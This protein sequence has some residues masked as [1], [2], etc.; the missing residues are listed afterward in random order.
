MSEPLTAA[1]LDGRIEALLQANNFGLSAWN[2]S[3]SSPVQFTF[4]FETFARSDYNLGSPVTGTFSEAERQAIRSA[5]QMFEQAINVRFTEVTNEADPIF[6][7]YRGDPGVGVG[8][9]GSWR[10]WGNEWDGSAIFGVNE[11][12]SPTAGFNLILHE[13]GHTLGLKH[14]GNYDVTGGGTEGPYLPTA[15]DSNKF[16]VMSYYENPD[17]GDVSNSL[18]L[19]DLAALQRFWG[20]NMTTRTGNDTYNLVAARPLAVIWDAGGVDAV[21]ASGAAPARIDLRAGTFSSV[22]ADDVLAI[23]YGVIVERAYGGAGNDRIIGNAAAN[24]L[25]GGA[26]ADRLDGGFGNDQ[27]FGGAGAD[28]LVGGAGNDTYVVDNARDVVVETGGGIDMVVSFV[29]TSLQRNSADNISLRGSAPIN[30]HGNTLA[31]VLGGNAAA[32]VLYGYAGNDRLAAGAGND[33]LIGGPGADILTGGLGLDVFR[34]DGLPT[35]PSLTDIVMDFNPVDDRFQL[36]LVAFNALNQSL[37]LLAAGSFA[38]NLAGVATQTDDRIVYD[39]DNGRLYYDADGVGGA[40]QRLI[41]RLSANLELTNRD[42]Q[43]Y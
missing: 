36:S 17:S 24:L 28:V 21:R 31:N 9:I 27:L 2:S 38:K 14:P 19:Y 35:S 5:W 41:A 11:T 29:S 3:F 15:E 30:A 16:T 4:Q 32:N 18:M 40:A 10:Y 20:A 37:G 7:L 13:L 39:I 12:L 42:F 8:G 25:D 26:G 1:Q 34:F 23:A 22:A 43:V 33:V 6:S